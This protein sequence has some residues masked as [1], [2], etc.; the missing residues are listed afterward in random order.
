LGI[1]KTKNKKGIAI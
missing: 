1:E